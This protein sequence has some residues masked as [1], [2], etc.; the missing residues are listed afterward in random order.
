MAVDL[1][2]QCVQLRLLYRKST[3]NILIHQLLHS[4]QHTVKAFAER[5]QFIPAVFS[6]GNPNIQIARLHRQHFLLQ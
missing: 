2:L 1:A 5:I 4:V 3:L 6:F